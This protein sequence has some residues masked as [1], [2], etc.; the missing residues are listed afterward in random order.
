MLGVIRLLLFATAAGLAQRAL[1]AAGHAIGIEDHPPVDVAR[2]AA[3]RLDQRRLRSQE[4]LLVG[5]EDR[6]QPAFG[7]VEPFAQQVDPYEHIVDTKSKITEDRKST[8]LNSS[9]Y[10]ASRMPHSACKNKIIN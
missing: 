10:C 4:P 8:R 3:D 9:H 7:N 6:D 1:H 2:R 5:V